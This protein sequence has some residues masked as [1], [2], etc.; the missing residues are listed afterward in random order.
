MASLWK[1]SAAAI[2][3]MA[4][5]NG[6]QSQ[7]TA[8]T[9]V[10]RMNVLSKQLH[11]SAVVSTNNTSGGSVAPWTQYW[12]T[13]LNEM[14]AASTYKSERIIVSPQSSGIEIADPRNPRR[15]VL[16]F[17]ANNYLGIADNKDVM[18][19]GKKMIDSHG[20][21]LSSVR[22]ICGT[23]DIHKELERVIA[24]FHGTEDA[25][26]YTSCFDANAGIFE[27]LLGP[28][29]AIFSDSLNH[30]S[31]IDGV[32]LAKAQK[33]RYKHLDLA[34]LEN[35]LKSAT[36]RIKLVVTDGVFSMDGEIAPLKEIVEVCERNGALLLVD[37]C[38]ATGFLGKTGR[39][40]PELCGVDGRVH[41][42]NSTLGKALGGASG[43]YTAGP[44]EA[45]DMLRQKSRP[46][47]F[48]N[49]LAPS[50][51]GGALEAFRM[52]STSTERRDIL[53]ENTKYFRS[54]M[55]AAGFTLKGETHPITP[56][57][58]FEA[59]L[60]AKFAEEML[61]E[62]I[63]VVGFFFPVVPRGEARIR[64]QISAAHTREQI[65]QAINAF[66]KVGKKLGV[67]KN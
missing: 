32:R 7:K 61:N 24:K 21:G 11:T 18:E 5:K 22:F 42:I 49:T 30:A 48:S 39:G 12:Q 13:S 1:P 17:C 37:E 51:V 3:K 43:G 35:Q 60:A 53:E 15:K 26:L 50:L 59:S 36:A 65:D 46:Y 57:M 6:S 62:G 55:K 10:R 16:N 2:R 52:L 28:E 38:H 20:F 66:I 41:L 54:K 34:D 19:A 23:Q 47:L 56:V 58:L 63:Y 8:S 29:D 27:A 9:A 4:T 33:F 64:T 44:K 45:I 67:L 40:T 31:I 14:K 25:I